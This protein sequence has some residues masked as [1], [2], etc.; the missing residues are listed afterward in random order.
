MLYLQLF[1]R[2]KCLLLADP[3]MLAVKVGCVTLVGAAVESLPL[4][5]WDNLTVG[6]ATLFTAHRMFA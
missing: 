3:T 2:L 1:G 4:R 5:D 6:A